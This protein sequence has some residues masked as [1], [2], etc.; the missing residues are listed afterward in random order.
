MLLVSS[1]IWKHHNY[2]VFYI[3]GLYIFFSPCNSAHL[4]CFYWFHDIKYNSHCGICLQKEVLTRIRREAAREEY[5]NKH[6][7]RFKRIFPPEDKFR[8]EKYAHLLNE[9]FKT[10]LSGRSSSLQKEIEEQY[11][12]KLRVRICFYSWSRTRL[13]SLICTDST[14]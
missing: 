13:H 2:R 8:R 12:Q 6:C 11:S 1:Q 7:N 14:E 9:S 5:E 10:F 4:L 3:N